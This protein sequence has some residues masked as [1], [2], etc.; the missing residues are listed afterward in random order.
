M[1]RLQQIAVRNFGPLT[2][3]STEPADITIIVG[4]NNTG[5]TAFLEAV[6]LLAA[7]PSR[8]RDA[9]DTPALPNI[10]S[11]RYPYIVNKTSEKPYA[12]IEGTIDKVNIKIKIFQE[13]RGDEEIW[14]ILAHIDEMI[15]IPDSIL[16]QLY[17]EHGVFNKYFK[18]FDY[19]REII[20]KI[21]YDIIANMMLKNP[22]IT[23]HADKSSLTLPLMSS[24]PFRFSTPD[25]AYQ[26]AERL[27]RMMKIPKDTFTPSHRSIVEIAHAISPYITEAVQKVGQ[28]LEELQLPASLKVADFVTKRMLKPEN[29]GPLEQIQLVE[30]IRKIV[31]YVIDIREEHVVLQHENQRVAVPLELMGSGFRALIDMLILAV[32]RVDLAVI[33][34]PELHMHPGYLRRTAELMLTAPTQF[35]AATQSLEFIRYLLKKAKRRND[36]HRIKL[37]RLYRLPEGYIDY[38]ELSGETAWL[39]LTKLKNDLRGP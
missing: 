19:F 5:K 17:E 24:D 37:L 21:S 2:E 15:E 26:I 25:I 9:L 39:H 29:L 30:E 10:L 6:V 35:I 28:K 18:T 14:D 36:L 32:K 31:N 27:E 23:V 16:R 3:I 20:L 34:E 7:A 1:A 8:F 11:R 22:I 33:D 4:R 13:P 12:E 38:E